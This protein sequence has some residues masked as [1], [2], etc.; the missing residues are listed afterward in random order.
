[1]KPKNGTQALLLFNY[2]SLIAEENLI[3]FPPA[4]NGG[5]DPT[6]LFINSDSEEKRHR[7]SPEETSRQDDHFPRLCL[8]EEAASERLG[9][10]ALRIM[11]PTV[12]WLQSKHCL[13]CP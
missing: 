2:E 12:C 9:G 3:R 11:C 5:G 10:A 4:G 6:D 13:S 8:W 7:K 1:M